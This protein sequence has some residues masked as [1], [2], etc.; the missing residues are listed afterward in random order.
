MIEITISDIM[1]TPD[2][3]LEFGDLIYDTVKLV[4][5]DAKK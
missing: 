4:N 3:I 2:S 5:V 1:E